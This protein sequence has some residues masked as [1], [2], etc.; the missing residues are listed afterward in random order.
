MTT[1]RL[2][3]FFFTGAKKLAMDFGLVLISFHRRRR[4]SLNI[5]LFFSGAPNFLFTEGCLGGSFF[6]SAP[7]VVLFDAVL[8]NLFRISAFSSFLL[9]SNVRLNELSVESVFDDFACSAKKEACGF[10]LRRRVAPAYACLLASLLRGAEH[11]SD[12]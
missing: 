5:G 12:L 10:S 1:L 4:S 6:N 9:F 8:L 2:N 7:G 11:F 3:Y